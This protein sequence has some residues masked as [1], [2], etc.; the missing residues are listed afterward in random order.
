MAD[1]SLRY[2]FCGFPC[3][4]P[5]ESAW[6]KRVTGSL[7]KSKCPCIWSDRTYMMLAM[8]QIVVFHLPYAVLNSHVSHVQTPRLSRVPR[9]TLRVAICM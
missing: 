9:D 5:V 1:V 6:M 2:V 3:D 7:I 8:L 4:K